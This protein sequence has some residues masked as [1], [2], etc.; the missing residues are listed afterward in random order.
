[1]SS[2]LSE[3]A[4]RLRDKYDVAGSCMMTTRVPGVHFY[5]AFE[6]IERTPIIFHS[7]IIIMIEGQKFGHIGD[8]TYRYDPE[9]YLALGLPLVLVCEGDASHEAP[10]SG[11]FIEVNRRS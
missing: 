11:L 9:H 8:R 3:L 5:C 7:G 10:L 4:R 6:P 2:T 1:M